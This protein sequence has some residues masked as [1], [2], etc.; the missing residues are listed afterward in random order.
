MEAT[1]TKQGDLDHL[2]NKSEPE[3]LYGCLK[4]TPIYDEA[5]LN[6]T[7]IYSPNS[8]KLDRQ[9]YSYQRGFCKEQISRF[10]CAV[11][12]DEPYGGKIKIKI[13]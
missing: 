7:A 1:T 13:F 8:T 10:V 6:Y 2:V 9:R 3:P 12:N 5:I 11:Y 4:P